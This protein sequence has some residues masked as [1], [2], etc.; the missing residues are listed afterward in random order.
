MLKKVF[1]IDSNYKNHKKV[2]IK[3][4]DVPL[5]KRFTA[6]LATYVYEHQSVKPDLT[7]FSEEDLN[8]IIEEGKRLLIEKTTKYDY[9][10]ELQDIMLNICSTFNINRKLLLSPT[11]EKQYVVAR[12]L[13]MYILIKKKYGGSQHVGH[14]I[15]RTHATVLHGV[16]CIE[17]FIQIPDQCFYPKIKSILN[18]YKLN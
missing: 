18:L 10:I 14:L 6:K 12:Q 15:K 1:V 11:R 3:V 7:I 4:F 5:N 2:G 16:K 8:Y 9:N 17:G 13:L